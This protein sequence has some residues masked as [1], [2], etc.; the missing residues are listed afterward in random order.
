MATKIP[1]LENF[2]GSYMEFSEGEDDEDEENE[3]ME[4]GDEDEE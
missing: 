4:S 2:D 3:D 1:P